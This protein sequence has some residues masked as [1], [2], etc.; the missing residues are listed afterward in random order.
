[1]T[2]AN[3]TE[4]GIL[5]CSLSLMPKNARSGRMAKRLLMVVVAVVVCGL[6]WLVLTSEPAVID[7]P[8]SVTESATDAADRERQ[9]TRQPLKAEAPVVAEEP[10]AVPS[11]SAA[12]VLRVTVLDDASGQPLEGS[13]VTVAPQGGGLLEA[14]TDGTGVA[15]FDP[16]PTRGADVAAHAPGL[17]RGFSSLQSAERWA[18]KGDQA[19]QIRLARGERLVGRVVDPDGQPIGGVDVDL[20]EGGTLG[21]KTSAS[22]G[23]L[24]GSDRTDAA[25]E[26]AIEGVPADAMVTLLAVQAGFARYERTVRLAQGGDGAPVE[27]QL[28][29]GGFVTGVV[30]GP[31]FVPVAR[32]QVLVAPS[33]LAFILDYSD[34]NIVPGNSSRSRVLSARTD[35]NGRY[36]VDGLTLEASYVALATKPGTGRSE[37]VNDVV[38]RDDAISVALDF[39]LRAVLELTVRVVDEAGERIEGASV[40]CLTGRFHMVPEG[41]GGV[42][43]IGG[44]DP[45]DVTCD[46]DADGYVK[47]RVI[48]A[49]AS[50]G[51]LVVRVE[52]GLAISGIA[53]DDT[54]EPLAGATIRCMRPLGAEYSDL[55]V[56]LAD[57]TT[58]E[59][60]R[61]EVQGLHSGPHAVLCWAAGHDRGKLEPV[62]A[63]ASDVRVVAP[64]NATVTLHLRLPTGA[65]RPAKLQRQISRAGGGSG[66]QVDWPED[67]RLVVEVPPIPATLVILVAGYADVSFALELTPGVTRD[68]GSVELDQGVT[69]I[70]LVADLDDRPIAG[71]EIAAAP[72]WAFDGRVAT[73]GDD[74]R[75]QLPRLARAQHEVEVYAEGFMTQSFLRD[76][77]AE[78]E[79]MVTLAR[80]GLVRGTVRTSEGVGI[81]DG[82]VWL[83]A[84][85]GADAEDRTDF[86][87]T[88]NAGRYAVRVLPGRYRVEYRPEDGDAIV[89]GE[90]T[91]VEGSE[92]TLDFELHD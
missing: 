21:G 60:G 29:R 89:G 39:Q 4:G 24:L 18:S 38:A 40:L 67:D 11:D 12:A 5:C 37:R 65:A 3:L 20:E 77:S 61:F 84:L 52:R 91:L 16:A 14:R 13:R 46:V 64:R 34:V 63:G 8:T 10:E 2:V 36:R 78:T 28:A 86:E 80:G 72:A 85:D 56:S 44:L 23:P 54:G 35:E 31:D 6:A 69:A 43:R 50:S 22:A 59:K 27:V 57:G 19:I 33:D 53:V 7:A 79:W 68:L 83:V 88:D 26:F 90:V 74:G 62:Q 51:E 17:V 55:P 47:Q 30:R 49:L 76:T 75:F 32:A 41:D 92:E 42:Y 1:V 87:Y 66:K 71:A 48:H 58:D 15:T 9:R 25:G 70:G 82:A 81:P 45:G 73:T